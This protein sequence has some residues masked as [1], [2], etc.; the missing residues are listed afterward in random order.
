LNAVI[1]ALLWWLLV[2]L[3]RRPTVALITALLFV[4]HPLHVEVVATGVGQAELVASTLALLAMITHLGL[5][6]G[7]SPGGGGE[8][9]PRR[10][11]GLRSALGL[12]LANLLYLAALLTKESAVVLPGLLFLADWLILERGRLRRMWSRI[13]LYAVYL[14]PLLV[15]ILMRSSVAGLDPPGAP[16]L[17][18]DL[19]AVERRVFASENLLRQVG[20]LFVPLGLVADYRDYRVPPAPTVADPIFLLSAVAWVATA[21]LVTLL[22]RRRRFT[23]VLA[24]AWFF[25]A[26]VPTC[27]LIVTIG[28]IRADRLLYLPSVGLCL[29]LALVIA[30]LGRFHRLL[31][32]ATLALI[33]VAHGW[34]TV[35]RNLVWRDAR[36]L[37][38]ATVA[39]NPGSANAHRN[40]A[41]NL[42]EAGEQPDRAAELYRRAIELREG[43]GFFYADARVQ[44]GHLLRARGDWALA[45]EQ[46]R[47]VVEERPSHFIAHVS[48]GQ[49]LSRSTDTVD[50]AVDVL[51]RAVTLQPD[52]FQTH[53]NLAHAFLQQGRLEEALAEVDEALA[54]RNSEAYV[55]SIRANI[56]SR[57]GRAEESQAARQRAASLGAR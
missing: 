21:S 28:T 34:I 48:L 17:V 16:E 19:G 24:I 4:S 11:R 32:F 45:A 31:P 46:Y 12:T 40:L 25:V 5:V 33:L 42:S 51:E 15:Y 54:L 9:R 14:I 49:V 23:A 3:L 30:K 41:D 52:N 20:Q 36:S 38:E 10:G 7:C 2:L 22:A 50:E 35:R 56:L 26:I 6:A 8:V 13:P 1:G 39:D 37:W 57:L 43:A 44:Y 27:N 29:G 53:A 55:W 18:R 47:R